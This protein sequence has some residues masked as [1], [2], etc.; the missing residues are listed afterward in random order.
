MS[1]L[2]K[3]TLALSRKRNGSAAEGSASRMW[4][5]SLMKTRDD[6]MGNSALAYPL[7]CVNSRQDLRMLKIVSARPLV[8]LSGMNGPVTVITSFLLTC[9][10]LEA[11][12][13]CFSPVLGTRFVLRSSLALPRRA[14]SQSILLHFALT[15]QSKLSNSQMWLA[16][17]IGIS[18][19]LFVWCY[20]M[21][22]FL[23]CLG[24]SKRKNE[25]RD[26]VALLICIIIVR[27]MTTKVCKK[28]CFFSLI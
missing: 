17:V 1:Y 28:W 10:R 8:L 15:M 2:S 6:N 26:L 9:D 5:L 24:A 4:S 23:F 27:Y 22:C 21:I 19:S 16:V 11:N 25:K 13:P 7:S 20:F 18:A 3:S 14:R 12:H